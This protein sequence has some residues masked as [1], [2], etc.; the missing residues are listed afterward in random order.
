MGDF[1]SSLISRPPKVSAPDSGLAAA[2]AESERKAKEEA[3]TLKAKQDEE[4][5]A[6][7][8]GRRGRRS[9]ISPEGVELGFTGL[10]GG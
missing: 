1:M 3:D 7:R 8:R 6:I 4:E 5:A 2:R 10:I 9:L